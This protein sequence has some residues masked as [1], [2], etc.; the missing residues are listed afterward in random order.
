L[1]E[2]VLLACAMAK[3]DDLGEFG[4]GDLRDP[5]YKITGRNIEIPAFA[6]HLNAF[7]SDA[8]NE[9]RGGVLVKRGTR[10]RFRYRFLD[11]LMPPYVLMKGHSHGFI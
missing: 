2:E 8:E 6:A 5:L 7:S 3:K 10:A 9:R 11:P 4:S 1:Y